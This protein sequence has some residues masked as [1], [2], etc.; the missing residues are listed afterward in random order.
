MNR[1]LLSRTLL[2][3]K[4]LENKITL[5]KPIHQRGLTEILLRMS[6]KLKKGKKINSHKNNADLTYISITSLL[7]F[8]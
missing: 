3:K 6:T 7:S 1:H 5:G 2:A 4:D 8:K